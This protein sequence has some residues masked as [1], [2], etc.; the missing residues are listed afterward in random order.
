M[1]RG[2]KINHTTFQLEA[3]DA[4]GCETGSCPEET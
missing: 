1:S 3:A 4:P 2:F